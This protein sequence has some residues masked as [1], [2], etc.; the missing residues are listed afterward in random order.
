MLPIFRLT[1]NKTSSNY[2][3][4]SIRYLTVYVREQQKVNLGIIDT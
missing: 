2:T 3:Q 4:N 1:R